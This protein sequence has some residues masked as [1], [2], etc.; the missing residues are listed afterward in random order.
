[1]ATVSSVGGSATNDDVPQPDL[2]NE[3]AA[4]QLAD[5]EDMKHMLAHKDLAL[6]Q[7][8]REDVMS[9]VGIGTRVL[10]WG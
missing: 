10:E 5:A 1:M 2:G 9:F 3:K 6:A 7:R 8:L 4:N